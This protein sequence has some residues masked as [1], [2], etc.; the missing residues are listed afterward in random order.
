MPLIF[1][2]ISQHSSGTVQQLL[3]AQRLCEEHSHSKLAEVMQG[4]VE[5][6]E[7]SSR[8][9]RGDNQDTDHLTSITT[10]EEG[11]KIMSR[12]N[13]SESPEGNIFHL[14]G[15]QIFSLSHYTV[16]VYICILLYILS[17]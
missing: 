8:G 11:Q 7:I 2:L 12:L 5:F 17:I 4:L 6:S 10:S 15:L 1:A 9:E 3:K 16:E 14:F 13:S